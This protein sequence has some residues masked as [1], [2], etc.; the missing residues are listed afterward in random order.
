MQYETDVDIAEEE[1]RIYDRIG[2]GGR[3]KL[4]IQVYIIHELWMRPPR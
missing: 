3:G 2:D 4:E 1:K